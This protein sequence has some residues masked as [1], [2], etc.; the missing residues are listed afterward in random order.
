MTDLVILG[1]VSDGLDEPEVRRVARAAL[2]SEDGK[3]AAVSVTFASKA[4]IRDLNRR[5]R[6]QDTPTDVL[7]Y[8]F[9]A[10]F[11]QG[12]GGEVIV[13]A[14]VV[15]ELARTDGRDA[16]TALK[17]AVVHGLLHVLGYED[18]TEQGAREMDR[19]TR[20]ILG[21]VDG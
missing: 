17:E 10:S 20:R 18:G 13:C 12:S 11:P 7:S 14:D 15:R 21:T 3:P 19:R 9:D 16:A 8:P 6:G 2:A 5:Y 1:D 4:T